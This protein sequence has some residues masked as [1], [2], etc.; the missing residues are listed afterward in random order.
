LKAVFIAAFRAVEVDVEDDLA[1]PLLQGRHKGI[2]GG[3]ERDSKPE[4]DL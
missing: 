3:A 1:I 2:H 4:H